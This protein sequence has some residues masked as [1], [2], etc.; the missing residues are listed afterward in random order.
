MILERV[1]RGGVVLVVVI[2]CMAVMTMVY[3]SL[4]RVGLS[5]RAQGEMEE[6][7]LQADWLAESGLE[8]AAARLAE[9]GDYKGETWEVTAAELGGP[10]GAVV[11]IAVEP[12][13][14]RPG[15]RLVTARADYPGGSTKRAR[16]VRRAEVELGPED[17]G[18]GR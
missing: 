16:Q 8:R 12:D 6:R 9:Y 10:W 11:T 1:R 17:S 2:V 3:G 18:G 5:R 13:E 4:L 15:R 7:R 14:D